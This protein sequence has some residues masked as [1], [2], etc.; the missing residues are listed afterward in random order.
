MSQPT[1]QPIG[2]PR[3][4]AVCDLKRP[5]ER[6]DRRVLALIAAYIDAGERSP[7]MKDMAARVQMTPEAIDV[8]LE[9]LSKLRLLWIDYSPYHLHRENCYPGARWKRNRYFLR[10]F[11]DPM[12]ESFYRVVHKRDRN[13]AVA[14]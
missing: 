11:G 5:L 8:S 10:G 14:A 9:R 6:D 1:K 13:Q 12:P 3:F 4:K 2:G 7:R